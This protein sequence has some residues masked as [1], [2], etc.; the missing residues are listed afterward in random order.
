MS[1]FP[2][3]P[4]TRPARRRARLRPSV[5]RAGLACA[6]TLL[7][8]LAMPANASAHAELDSVSPAD[9]ST[10]QG[11]PTEIVMTFTQNLDP[12]KSSI[13]VVD[14][15]GK[16]VVQGGTVAAGSPRKMTLAVD[17]ALQPG[18]YTIRWTSFSS[19]DQEQARGTTSFTVTAAPTPSP[20]PSP[21]VAPSAAP[22]TGP[23]V[24]PTAAP[25]VQPSPSSPPAAPAASTSDALIPIVAVLVILAALGAWLMRNRARGR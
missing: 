15:G 3:V 7:A 13:R 21:T 14:P 19:E 20:S 25:T 22:S 9:K 17:P 18:A 12:A 11:S 16:V 8:A 4:A 2:S 24:A 23:S 10:V 1:T 5:I 6:A